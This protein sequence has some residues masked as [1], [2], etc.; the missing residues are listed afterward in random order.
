MG[1]N[2][3]NLSNIKLYV[4]LAIRVGCR[5]RGEGGQVEQ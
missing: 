4:T 2:I 3:L 1:Q 5:G